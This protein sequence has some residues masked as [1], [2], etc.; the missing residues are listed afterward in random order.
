VVYARVSSKEQEQ[1]YSIPAQ[2]QLLRGYAARM[3]MAVAQEFVDVESAKTT[4]RQGFVAMVEHLRQNPSCRVV[5]AEK[6]DRLYRNLKDYL[7]LDELGLEIHMV[8]ENEIL[9]RSSRS[10]QK[11]M[12]GIRVLMAKNYIDN[13]SEEVKKGLHTKA[14]QHL[15]PSFAPPG[16][17]NAVDGAGKRIIE[18]DP[19]LGPVVTK[20]F[21]WFASGQY[22]LKSVARKAYAEGFRFRKSQNKVPVTTLHK[23][24]RKRIYTGDFDYAGVTYQG[25][26]VPLV[27]H[28]V[29]N[30]VQHIL[31]GRQAANGCRGQREFPYSGM[32][33][34]GHCG[35]SLVGEI[36]KGRYV[37]YHC[38]GYRGKCGERYTREE[39]LGQQFA[40]GVRAL[41]ISPEIKQWLTTELMESAEADQRARTAAG[42]RDEAELERARARLNMLYEDRL[43]GRIDAATYDCKA[44]AIRDEQLK[45]QQK[46]AS[47][48][49]QALPPMQQAVETMLRTSQAAA[50]FPEASGAEQRRLLRLVLQEA[51]WKGGELRMSLKEPFEE[52]RLSN[53]VT[54]T[55]YEGLGA[56]EVKFDNWR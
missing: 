43:D 23:I 13:L 8:K 39:T 5:L 2:Q 53:S 46:I 36:K 30:R 6:T 15:W 1:G 27:A 42:R 4:G 33:S 12:Q 48:E 9:S 38:T 18:P 14:S 49:A 47:A 16:Y 44:C 29:W 55:N 19:V 7:T 56:K 26:H 40:G 50:E 11:F 41:I 22:S 17:R 21:E 25:S 52:L 28:E 45:I 10:A 24:L 3:G 20:L 51:S 34:C 54:V 35:C 31:D 37:Y 32:V